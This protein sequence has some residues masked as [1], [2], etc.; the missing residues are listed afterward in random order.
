MVI[1]LGIDTWKILLLLIKCTGESGQILGH[2]QL[3]QIS[4]T[5]GT[6]QTFI[7][8]VILCFSST[9]PTNDMEEC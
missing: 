2:I 9:L 6:M 8:G 1:F 3:V 4:V 5:P 7:P